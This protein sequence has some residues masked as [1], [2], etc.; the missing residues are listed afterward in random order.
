VDQN[1]MVVLIKERGV[2]DLRVLDAMAQVPRHLFVR[3]A[4]ADCAYGDFALPIGHEQTISQPY[5]VALMTETLRLDPGNRV[6]EIGTGS[7]YQAAILAAMG[8]EVYSVER[9]PDLYQITQDLLTG[10]GYEVHC[11]LGDGYHGWAEFAPYRGIVVTAAA[12]QIPKPLIAQLTDGGHLVIPTGRPHSYQS[13]VHIIKEG[14]AIHKENLGGVAF[15][16]FVSTDL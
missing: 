14:G 12:P 1:E 6:L 16:P 3:P 8:M 7:G 10:L 15:V 2:R 4:Q 13:L 11:K 9:I 5:I